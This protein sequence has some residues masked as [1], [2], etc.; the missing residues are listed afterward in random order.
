MVRC[1]V[2]VTDGFKMELGLH[3][4]SALSPF[5]FAV[6]IDRMTGEIMQESPWTIMFVD[7]LVIC[8]ETNRHVEENLERRYALDGSKAEFM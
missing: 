8:N 5:L 3:Q 6:M 2:V 4:G 1:A 7:D